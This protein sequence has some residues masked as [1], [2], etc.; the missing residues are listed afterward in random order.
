MNCILSEKRH[1]TDCKNA[2]NSVSVLFFVK[3]GFGNKLLMPVFNRKPGC[4]F[5]CV[6]TSILSLWILTGSCTQGRQFTREAFAALPK[7]G[8][9]HSTIVCRS[10]HSRSYALLIPGSFADYPTA[11]KTPDYDTA[12]VPLFPLIIAFDP[13]G[14][15]SLPIE[16]YKSLAERFGYL[17]VGS[18]DIKNGLPVDTTQKIIRTL[19]QEI[20][21]TYPVDTGRVYLMGFSGGARVASLT[22]L[23]FLK[24][25][26]VIG[27]G[28]G[29]SGNGYAP[30]FQFDY[31]G[32]AGWGDFNVGE[33][34]S[35]EKPLREAGFRHH[36]ATWPGIHEWPPEEEMEKAFLWISTNAMRDRQILPDTALTN[37]IARESDLEISTNLRKEYLPDALAACRFALSCLHD[38]SPLSSFTQFMDSITHS[39]L[40][41]RQQQYRESLM[42]KEETEQ[43]QLMDAV[44]SKDMGWWKE[45]KVNMATK[46][47]GG[48]G[49]DQ[50]SKFKD[51]SSKI[52]DQ[53]SKFK[54]QGK[55]EK[56]EGRRRNVERESVH[57]KGE[58]ENCDQKM[59]EDVSRETHDVDF[60]L[61]EDTLYNRRML[62]F[63]GLYCYMQSG[64]ELSKGSDPT[65]AKVIDIYELIEPQN[66]EAN[67]LRARVYARQ[68]K[69]DLALKQLNMA[70][71]KGFNDIARME[72]Q[73]EF[74]ALKN[75][76]GFKDIEKRLNNQ[77]V[78][79][80]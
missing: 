39:S 57:G 78:I 59:P 42:R 34:L 55:S 80:R 53:R 10:D 4:G 18:N 30:P 62:A 46:N 54:D 75:D 25:R 31:Y 74:I 73:E 68:G 17:M 50:G 58:P 24:V 21:T 66:P 79:T 69:Q 12:R 23:Y 8:I 51:Q 29:F 28:A 35:L 67:Y 16:R 37:L 63:M 72:S 14:A 6:F 19:V 48:N 44:L 41:I 3:I 13:H 5:A 27:C 76:Q 43:Q 9:I 15:G 61:R 33:L 77:K 7:P 49:K 36:I 47:K 40:Y 2:S 32:M 71:V 26:G 56:E 38:L 64:S 65:A 1:V 60:F 52:K 70:I 45:W 22:G 11:L 20:V